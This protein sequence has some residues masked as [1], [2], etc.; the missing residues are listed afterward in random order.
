M[1]II[2]HAGQAPCITPRGKVWIHSRARLAEGGEL[3]RLQGVWLD[4]PTLRSEES[5]F[6][7]DLAG[8]GFNS[9]CMSVAFLSHFIIC[10]EMHRDRVAELRRTFTYRIPSNVLCS[11]TPV[12]NSDSESESLD[13]S[14]NEHRRVSVVSWRS[15]VRRLKR[16]RATVSEPGETCLVSSDA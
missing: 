13:W 2:S 7:Q 11:L 15:S 1:S 5:F 14:M 10:S 6:L 12:P 9:F 3:F 4:E 16:A 8:N